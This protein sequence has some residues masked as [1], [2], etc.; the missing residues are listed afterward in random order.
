M[1][2]STNELP[3]TDK[4]TGRT[5]FVKRPV[6]LNA[7]SIAAHEQPC[8]LAKLDKDRTL[9]QQEEVSAGM[10]IESS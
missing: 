5:L 3:C 6:L 8:H 10:S 7:S 4:V 2:L 1:V 9:V